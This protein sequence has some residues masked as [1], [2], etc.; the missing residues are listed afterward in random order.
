MEVSNEKI[1]PFFILLIV[2]V[3]YKNMKL[4]KTRKWTFINTLI[5]IAPTATASPRAARSGTTDA[6]NASWIVTLTQ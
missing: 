5:Y 3:N 6:I 4:I 1:P 2:L